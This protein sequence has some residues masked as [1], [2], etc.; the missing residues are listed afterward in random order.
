MYRKTHARSHPNLLTI[1][2]VVLQ[3]HRRM[4]DLDFV[5]LC[6]EMAEWLKALAWKACIP[7]PVSWVRIPLSPPFSM[8]PAQNA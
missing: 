7:L 2:V 8:H 4:I 1:N 6:G 3:I 5:D